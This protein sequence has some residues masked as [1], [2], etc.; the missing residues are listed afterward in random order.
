MI[1]HVNGDRGKQKQKGKK[2]KPEKLHLTSC[3][4]IYLNQGKM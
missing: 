3:M 2:P 1:K 4:H